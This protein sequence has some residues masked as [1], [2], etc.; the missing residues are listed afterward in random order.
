MGEKWQGTPPCSLCG[1]QTEYMHG[2]QGLLGTIAELLSECL[3]LTR[4]Q[5]GNITREE[6][7]CGHLWKWSGRTFH[8]LG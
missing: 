3:E 2:A 8:L 6:L 7:C 4:E 1:S 5:R